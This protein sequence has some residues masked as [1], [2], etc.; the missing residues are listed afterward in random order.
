MITRFA[1]EEIL[2]DLASRNYNF[3]AN[4]RIMCGME[5]PRSDIRITILFEL[6][7]YL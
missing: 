7:L 4:P 3:H 6:G 2:A 1:H 5:V